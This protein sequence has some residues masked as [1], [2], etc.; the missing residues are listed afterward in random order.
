[1]RVERHSS[2][3]PYYPGLAP[4]SQRTAHLRPSTNFAGSS[5]SAENNPAV[6]HCTAK[7]E[8]DSPVQSQFFRVICGSRSSPARA[9]GSF[10]S[11]LHRSLSSMSFS[12]ALE[13]SP[14]LIDMPQ[15]LLSAAQ[16]SPRHAC[17]L[18]SCQRC[19]L[20]GGVPAAAGHNQVSTPTCPCVGLSDAKAHPRAF[21]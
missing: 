15:I 14:Q 4:L 2:L 7:Q 5:F 18:S 11:R 3:Q 16:G 10:L 12:H 1:V 9:S 13:Q 19:D 8:L 17:T 20:H 21:R 6:A